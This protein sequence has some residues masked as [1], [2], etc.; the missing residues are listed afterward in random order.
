MDLN[1]R[2]NWLPGMEITAQ[3]FIGLEEKLDFQQQIAIRAALGSTQMGLLPGAE[4]NCKGVFVKNTFEVENLRCM[5][6][7][8]S[9]KIIDADEKAV[10]PIPMLFGDSYYLTIGISDTTTAYEKEGVPYV[11]PHY[12]YAILSLEEVEAQDVM[13]LVHFNVND[14]MFSID[15]GYIPPCLLMTG[16]PQFAAFVERYVNKLSA[17]TS[18]Q[19]LE[20]GDGKRALLH[21]L[22]IMKGYSLRTSVHNF[23][24]QLQE[25]AHAIDYYIITP[26]SDQAVTIPEPTQVDIQKWLVGFDDYLTGAVAV[27]DKVVLVDNSIDYD[28]LLRQAKAELYAQL[29]EELIVK[30]L[31]ETKQ[32]LIILVKEE[33]E[34]GLEQQTK[35]ITDYVNNTMKPALMEELHTEMNNSLNQMEDRLK[36]NLYEHLY[37]ELFEHLFNALYVPEPEDERFIPLI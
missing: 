28:A 35:T 29:H 4:L 33:L 17:I 36:M 20:E 3:T 12:E 37:E 14:G 1:S 2:I 8:P 5:A 26:N 15:M 6:L 13:P 30:L 23:M 9:G 24:M 32:K 31:E 34:K 27:L 22:F 16:H 11:R 7:L 18:H 21:Y 10:I 19:N 25:I